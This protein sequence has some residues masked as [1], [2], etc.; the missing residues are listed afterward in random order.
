[1]MS[2]WVMVVRIFASRACAFAGA[3]APSSF[4]LGASAAVVGGV[5]VA[6]AV[7][8]GCPA[9]G[10]FSPDVG[11]VAAGGGGAEPQ[12]R[13]SASGRAKATRRIMREEI[14]GPAP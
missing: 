6:A 4:F 11:G 5:A 12:P 8:A 1:M 10:A 14:G 7:A 2:F 13:T 9:G 3:C